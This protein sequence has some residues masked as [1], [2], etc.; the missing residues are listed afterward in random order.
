MNELNNAY[1]DAHSHTLHLT[2]PLGCSFLHLPF[3]FFF[4]SL[5]S[6]QVAIEG[7]CHGE[8]DAIY[9]TIEERERLNNYNVDLL[10]ICGDVQV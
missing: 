2:D 3:F 8:L 4:G 5:Y 6:G 7:C 9:R 1:L 10:L